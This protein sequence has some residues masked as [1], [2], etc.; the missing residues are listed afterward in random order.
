MEKKRILI[1]D[2]EENMCSALSDVLEEEGFFVS[3]AIDREEALRLISNIEFDLLILDIRLKGT[4]GIK[5]LSEVKEINPHIKVIIMTGYPSLDSAIEGT[6]LGITDYLLK[7]ISMESLKASIQNALNQREKEK[8]KLELSKRLEEA[9]KKILKLEETLS[10]ATKLAS[11][12]KIG[13]AMFHEVKN[14]LSI[15]NIST[16]YLK[17]NIET[18]DPKIKKHLEIIEKEIEHSHQIIMGLL[19]LSR[20]EE[21]TI[22]CDINQLL[23]EAV[24]LMSHELE[25]KGIKVIKDYA[26]DIPVVFLEPNEI[27]QVFVNLILNA[28]DAMPK[29]G[30]LRIITGK[31][32]NCIYIK[33][34]DTGCGIKKKDLE[35]I[36]TP[37]FTTKKEAGGM[38]LGLVVSKE[39]VEKYGGSI[40]VES[41]ENKGAT[42]T[43]K[44]SLPQNK[45]VR[46]VVKQDGKEDKDFNR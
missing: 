32:D 11:L 40:S 23:E 26:G 39:I 37:F 4:D 15:M 29:G 10:Q 22:P 27:K 1:V 33:F 30:E 21:K 8:E 44:F 3:T 43:I 31:D 34:S 36:F 9:E 35:K 24:S 18:N 41:E 5:L 13:P 19:N 2:D 25:L 42:F 20:K 46:E 38:G 14:I 7:P 45:Q 28:E 16:Y 6:R 17:R 12:G